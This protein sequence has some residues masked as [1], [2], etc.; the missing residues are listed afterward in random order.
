MLGSCDEPLCSAYDLTMFDLDGVVYIS[1]HAVPGAPEAIAAVRDSGA[2]VA[3][4]TNNASR[5][6]EAVAENLVRL[7]VQAWED[8]IV[9]SAQAA[10]RVLAAKLPPESPVLMV[11]AE[12]L[13]RALV[14]EALVP[15]RDSRDADEVRA[16]VTGYGPDVIWRDVMKAAVLIRGGLWWVASNTDLTLPTSFGV[17]PGHGA[18]VRMLEQFS[19]VAPEVAG[20]PARPLF[21]ETLRRVGGQRPLM[22]GDRLDTDIE[23]AHNAGVDSLLVMTGVTGLPELV[24]ATPEQRPT[25]LSTGLTGLLR[26]H[27]EVSLEDGSASVGGWSA[28]VNDGR[29]AVAGAGS[30]DAWWRAVASVA[31]THLDET[32]S[33]A[34]HA[35]LVPPEAGP[36]SP[37]H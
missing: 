33:V 19:G 25:Y 35:D 30:P 1:G 21:E 7:G 28:R 29:V 5:P 9:T 27:P 17:A 8:D 26:P 6:P 22:V 11:G 37:R 34:D 15:V 16:V 18:M 36:G 14:E 32:G 23:G 3:F 10:A 24:S 31:W 12:G 4:I 13:A 20:K 2:R